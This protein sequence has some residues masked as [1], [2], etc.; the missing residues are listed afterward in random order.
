MLS[1]LFL[2]CAINALVQT[3]TA[4]IHGG[5]RDGSGGVLPGATVCMA[6]CWFAGVSEVRA[7]LLGLRGA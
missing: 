4:E 1:L 6:N 3:N 5:V 7:I 2:I